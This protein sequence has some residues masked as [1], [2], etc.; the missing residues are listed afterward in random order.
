MAR[1][2]LHVQLCELEANWWNLNHWLLLLHL[3]EVVAAHHAWGKLLTVES[4]LPHQHLHVDVLV[5][6]DS[7][8]LEAHLRWHHHVSELVAHAAHVHVH[9]GRHS[10]WLR[11]HITAHFLGTSH[12]AATAI[13]TSSIAAAIS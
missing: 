1:T 7:L 5:H 12:T 6:E 13:I 2:I 11:R 9:C 8:V 4:W 3:H 10:L